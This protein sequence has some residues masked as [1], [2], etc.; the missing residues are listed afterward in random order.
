MTKTLTLRRSQD[1]YKTLSTTW[2]VRRTENFTTKK[3]DL[4]KT[5]PPVLLSCP[6]LICTGNDWEGLPWFGGFWGGFVGEVPALCGLAVICW[7]VCIWVL[8]VSPPWRFAGFGRKYMIFCVYITI[9]VVVINT[10]K[11]RK[12]ADALSNPANTRELFRECRECRSRWQGDTGIFFLEAFHPFPYQ[13]G[14]FFVDCFVVSLP[15]WRNRTHRRE[16][17]S[18]FPNKSLSLSLREIIPI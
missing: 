3:D 13:V 16:F 10:E 8:R 9:V 18:Q 2:N 14:I 6:M 4:T 7:V 15:A 11:R 5:C 1:H 12:S 17:K